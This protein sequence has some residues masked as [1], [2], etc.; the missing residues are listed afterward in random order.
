MVT[1][2]RTTGGTPIARDLSD[3]GSIP[4]SNGN[5]RA[6]DADEDDPTPIAINGAPAVIGAAKA[7]TAIEP[8]AADRFAIT[9][10]FVL[11]N[12][13]TIDAPNVQLT[14][15]L[16]DAFAGTAA[17]TVTAGPT[18][19]G[20]LSEANAA[21]DGDSDT[22][23]LSG[24][25]TLL[26]GATA[27]VELTVEVDTGGAA[28][29]FSNQAFA[30]TAPTPNGVPT[31]RDPSDDGSDPDPNGNGNPNEPGENDPTTVDP[32]STAPSIGLAKRLVSLTQTGTNSY[33]AAFR[34]VLANLS[35]QVAAPNV[36][37]TDDLSRR[38]PGRQ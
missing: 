31:S 37:V 22:R 9:Y 27:S 13:S 30:T 26:P 6:D 15:S 17:V 7:V 21:F 5:G 4:D 10:R 24:S 1:S 16:A 20:A 38:L 18:V 36:Q 28:G 8:L 35:T 19:T 32:A 12:L 33:E 11:E 23:L 14:D 25:E 29:P 34:F 2:A 3:N